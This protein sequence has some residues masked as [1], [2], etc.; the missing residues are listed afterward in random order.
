[1][2]HYLGLLAHTLDRH[3]EADQWFTQALA[4][5]EAMEAPFFVALT[6]A[7][8]AALLADRNEP[9]DAE[10]ARTLVDA[11]L[12]VATERGYGYIERDAR[13]VLEQLA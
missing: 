2:A 11:V 10:R 5:H 3:G 8:W 9:G 1:M 12:P 13:A 7:A 4:F 6:Q